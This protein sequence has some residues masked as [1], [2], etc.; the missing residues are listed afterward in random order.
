VSTLTLSLQ[1][2]TFATVT[3]GFYG[4][5]WLA[6]TQKLLGGWQVQ[7]E[8]GYNPG[9]TAGKAQ[10]FDLQP[11]SAFSNFVNGPAGSTCNQFGG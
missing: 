8:S 5:G 4:P 10:Y 7:R 2:L 11:F 6:D 3:S 1:V 9:W